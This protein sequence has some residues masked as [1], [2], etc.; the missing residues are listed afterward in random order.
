MIVDDDI[1][2]EGIY[3]NNKKEDIKWYENIY[4]VFAFKSS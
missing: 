4:I 1:V 3:S 2:L